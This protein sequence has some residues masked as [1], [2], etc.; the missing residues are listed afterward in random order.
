MRDPLLPNHGLTEKQFQARSP[1][2]EIAIDLREA[3]FWM[4]S[5]LPTIRELSP[6]G[7][8]RVARPRQPQTSMRK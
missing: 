2:R 5:G 4:A 7:L 3:R 1:L 8:V 6:G